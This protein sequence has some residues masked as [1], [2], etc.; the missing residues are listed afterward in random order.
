MRNRDGKMIKKCPITKKECCGGSRWRR[1]K[2]G[3]KKSKW[4]AK[5]SKTRPLLMEIMEKEKDRKK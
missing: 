3:E 1:D 4:G 5:E 2:N